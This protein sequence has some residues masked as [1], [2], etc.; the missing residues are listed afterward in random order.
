MNRRQRRAIRQ[1]LRDAQ[2]QHIVLPGSG[3]IWLLYLLAVAALV[4]YL[5]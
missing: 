4:K 5:V 1:V 3:A 2:P